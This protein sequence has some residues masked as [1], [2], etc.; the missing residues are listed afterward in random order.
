MVLRHALRSAI[1]VLAVSVT[2]AAGGVA[3]T[4]SSAGAVSLTSALPGRV[5]ST[6]FQPKGS[7]AGSETSHPAT[8]TSAVVRS[9]GG[10]RGQMKLGGRRAALSPDSAA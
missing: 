4:A 7:G 5:S 8:T 1:A 3:V 10:R 9:G 2:A 6:A